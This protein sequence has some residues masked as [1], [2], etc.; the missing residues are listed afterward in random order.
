M[1][2][3]CRYITLLGLFYFFLLFGGRLIT[4]GQAGDGIFEVDLD[5][6]QKQQAVLSSINLLEPLAENNVSLN[7]YL[8]NG[9]LFNEQKEDLQILAQQAIEKIERIKGNQEIKTKKGV[10]HRMLTAN[11][12]VIYNKTSIAILSLN[13][14]KIL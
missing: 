14:E 6:P 8:F 2:F 13:I 7:E 10:G 1:Y 5:P 4:Q 3:K 12:H 9:Y 11:A